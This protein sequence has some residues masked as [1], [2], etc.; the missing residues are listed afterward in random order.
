[1]TF[2]AYR[3][4]GKWAISSPNVEIMGSSPLRMARPQH[5]GAQS[6]QEASAA[7]TTQGLAAGGD[8]DL[9]G[10]PG[11]GWGSHSLAAATQDGILPAPG[12]VTSVL[13]GPDCPLLLANGDRRW[14]LGDR[15]CLSLWEGEDRC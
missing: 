15:G 14:S 9:L 11:A 5:R 4:P 3:F 6:Q 12:K 13:G 7:R 1:M 2:I 8:Q 10:T